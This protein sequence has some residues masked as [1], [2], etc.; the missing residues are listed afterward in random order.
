[1]YGREP[2]AKMKGFADKNGYGNWE[3]M[4]A[5]S[6]PILAHISDAEIASLYSAEMRG[7]AQ[8]YALATNFSSLNRLRFLW[9]Q[10]FLK[11]MGN[12]YKTSMQQVANMLNRGS[13]MAVREK[14]EKGKIREF[15]LFRLKDVKRE[16][17]H[18]KEVDNHPL[19]FKYTAGSELL[20]RIDANQCEYCERTGGYFEV[21]HIRKLADIKEGVCPTFYT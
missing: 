10:S 16:A 4:E 6:R 17:I 11:S 21:H 9:I 2:Q 18:E 7:F 8:Y 13:Y 19:R 1:V 20:R 12:K 5:T 14:G 3:T 15:K